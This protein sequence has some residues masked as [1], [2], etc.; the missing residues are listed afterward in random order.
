MIWIAFTYSNCIAFF[1]FRY[2]N[3]DVVYIIIWIL[4]SNVSSVFNIVRLHLHFIK[5]FIGPTSSH[6]SL[7]N[8][9]VIKNWYVTNV[10]FGVLVWL[11]MNSTQ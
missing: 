8:N 4:Y 11:Q 10:I 3:V 6:V 5:K 1:N 2:L 9:P 7:A